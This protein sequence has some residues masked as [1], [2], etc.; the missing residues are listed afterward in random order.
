M[1]VPNTNISTKL[2]PTE[3]ILQ[4][5]LLKKWLDIWDFCDHINKDTSTRVNNVF[6]FGNR[7]LSSQEVKSRV[8]KTNKKVIKLFN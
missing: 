3:K 7:W 4:N 2:S 5:Q 1:W 6:E 8:Y